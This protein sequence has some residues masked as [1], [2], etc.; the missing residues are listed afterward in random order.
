MTTYRRAPLW[1][2]L[3]LS[4]CAAAVICAPICAMVALYAIE[5]LR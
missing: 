5:V 1:L 2:V 3:A 4:F